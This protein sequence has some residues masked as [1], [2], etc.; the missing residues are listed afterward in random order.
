[1]QYN[2]LFRWIVGLRI[3]DPV[4]GR[5]VFTKNRDRFLTSEMSLKAIAAILAQREVAPLLS[6][7]CFSVD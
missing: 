7:D 1:M 4:W 5:T 3:D 2:L 6:D